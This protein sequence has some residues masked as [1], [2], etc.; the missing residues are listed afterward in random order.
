M[1]V[2]ER[3]YYSLSLTLYRFLIKK[4]NQTKNTHGNTAK[5]MAHPICA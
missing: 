2:M 1:K 4:N 5:K 3:F